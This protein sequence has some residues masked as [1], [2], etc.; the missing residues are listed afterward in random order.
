MVV[1]SLSFPQPELAKITGDTHS[2]ERQ[3]YTLI[4]LRNH[5]TR[6]IYVTSQPLHP[7]I[8]DYDLDLAIA[9]R[10]RLYS[11]QRQC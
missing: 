7:S 3:R 4:Q 10:P 1:L 8:I 6:M 2:E 11:P 9:Q 5:C